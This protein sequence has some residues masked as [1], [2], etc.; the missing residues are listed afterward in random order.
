MDS[1][2]QYLRECRTQ[3]GMSLEELAARTRIRL[4]TLQALERD[5]YPALPVEVT[6]KGF[7]RAYARCLGLDEQDVLVRYQRFA[8][9][10]FQI[11]QDANPIGRVEQRVMPE[12]FWRRNLTLVGWTL[13]GLVIVIS[14][15]I[16]LKPPVEREHPTSIAVPGRVVP[17]A[18][19][20]AGHTEG[21]PSPS[22]LPTPIAPDHQAPFLPPTGGPSGS[23]QSVPID[24]AHLQ[25]LTI[26][27]TETSW[28]QVT[29]DGL[30][31][32]EA[33]L[34]PG[35][36][37]TWEAEHD[38][39]LTVGNA[40][41]VSV[42]LNGQPVDSLGPSGRVRT[43]VLPKVAMNTRRDEG[44]DKPASPGSPNG[45]ARAGGPTEPALTS[46]P[47]SVTVPSFP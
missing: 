13:A 24:A 28:V 11:A 47:G 44:A 15:L 45:G 16:A 39:R 2:G 33:L 43:L 8:A 34:Q 17:P 9:E 10:Y 37:V 31:Q 20:P 25:R 27:A 30:Q 6:V 18:P 19:P 42:A 7:L 40:G 26:A 22:P 1:L 12:P 23:P 35:E 36:H 21:V 4:L 41:G 3:R 14:S 29:I 32:K 46:S 5:D 38:F